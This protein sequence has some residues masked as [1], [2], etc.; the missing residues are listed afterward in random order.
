MKMARKKA[1]GKKD[2]CR[3]PLS[4][5]E[6]FVVGHKRLTVNFLF[7]VSHSI[8]REIFCWSSGKGYFAVSPTFGS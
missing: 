4:A 8:C 7:V 3:E 6:R 2:L 1:H 5:K